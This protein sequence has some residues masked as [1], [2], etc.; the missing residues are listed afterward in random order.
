MRQEQTASRSEN[1]LNRLPPDA[2]LTV[3]NTRLIKVVEK[4]VQLNVT[5]LVSLRHSVVG[6][7]AG[8][9]NVIHQQLKAILLILRVTL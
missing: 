6:G 9:Q 4:V 1:G 2:H 3:H 7:N 8:G 5:F